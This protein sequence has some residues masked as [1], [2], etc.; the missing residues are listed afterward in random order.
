L[1]ISTTD[2]KGNKALTGGMMKRQMP[3][4]QITNYINVKSIDEYCSKIEKLGGK[5][6]ILRV[7]WQVWDILQF[8]L[9][10][11]ITVLLFGI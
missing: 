3:Q 4:Q 5:V 10:R 7:Q 9:I 2:E 1:I 8:V 11:K 6:I